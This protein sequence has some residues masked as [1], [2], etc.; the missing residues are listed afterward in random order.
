LRIIFAFRKNGKNRFRLNPNQN[1]E[2]QP[3]ML[4]I[5]LWLGFLFND[6]KSEYTHFEYTLQ[7]TQ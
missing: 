5:W 6:K 7:V 1:Q 4:E 3:D 2:L